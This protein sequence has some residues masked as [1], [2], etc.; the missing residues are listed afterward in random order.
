MILY[1]FPNLFLILITI[2]IS[3]RLNLIPFWLSFLLSLLAFTP[4]FL[5]NVLFHPSYMPDQF[6][7]YHVTQDIRSL[8]FGTSP[9]RTIEAASWMFAF[10][11]MPY[12][13]TIQ[14][15]GF[16][17]R[18]IITIIIIWLYASKNLRGWPLIFLVFYP[19]LILYSSLALRDTL[20]FLFMIL[21]IIYFIENR[22]LL[23]LFFSLPLLFIKYQNFA[24][25]IIFFI[26]HLYFEKGSF[27][28]RF[29][30]ILLT[31]IIVSALPFIMTII[32]KL[33]FLRLA[34]FV[35]DGGDP[36]AY[37]PIT[38][39]MDFFI[40]SIKSAPYFFMKPFPWETDS[41]LQFIQSIENVFLFIFLT[42]IYLKVSTY[43]KKIS[44]K[45]FIFLVVAFSIYGLMVYNFGT[46]VRYKFPFILIII[47]GM[48]RELYL[49]HGKLIL[50]K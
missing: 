47:I 9:H 39:F 1:D 46:A 19:S 21:S 25:L 34:L 43:D 50:N 44:F 20:V 31:I 11:P 38:S 26:I 40:L 35:E 22:R 17:N 2:I 49:K 32:D 29:R 42:F 41:F 28:Y 36:S 33:D 13:E 12:V 15:L 5:N 14:S 23:A 18:F 6:D 27:F 7:Y 4:F 30:H 48:S 24:I 10:L 3:F 8:T 45:W 16:F 37:D